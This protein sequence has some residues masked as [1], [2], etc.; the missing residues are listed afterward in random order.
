MT[1]EVKKII[2]NISKKH[3]IPFTEK[4]FKLRNPKITKLKKETCISLYRELKM[5]ITEISSSLNISRAIIYQYIAPYI[6]EQINKRELEKD[7]PEFIIKIVN[8]YPFETNKERRMA[9]KAIKES[10][11]WGKYVNRKF[12]C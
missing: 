3:N 6:E 4:H 12:N 10:V 11:Q 5:S 1:E 2:D 9:I 8:S 7:T